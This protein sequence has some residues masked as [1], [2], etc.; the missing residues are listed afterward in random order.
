MGRV[1]TNDDDDEVAVKRNIAR[2]REKWAS[3][4]R[5]LITDE[6]D[7]KTMATFYRTVVLYVLLYGSESWVLTK[8]MIRQLRSFHR[9][10]CR[11][12][13]G[14]FIHQDEDGEWI[15]PS[16]DGVMEKAGV[17]TIEEYLQRRRDSILPYA[18]TR[19]IYERCKS[20]ERIGSKLLWWEVNYFSNDAAEAPMGQAANGF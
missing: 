2:A 19:K 3:M 5:F 17:L 16:S 14:E 20:S 12:L 9:R 1:V 8:D 7:P 13:T 10:C 6:A 15:C 11:G 4:R 18:E